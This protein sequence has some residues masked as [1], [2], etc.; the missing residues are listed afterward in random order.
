MYMF[1]NFSWLLYL[2]TLKTEAQ[3]LQDRW[4]LS[5]IPIAFVVK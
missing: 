4:H 2:R 3:S 5:E 1:F